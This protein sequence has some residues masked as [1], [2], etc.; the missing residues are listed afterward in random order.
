MAVGSREGVSCPASSDTRTE[1]ARDTAPL[2]KTAVGAAFGA[3]LRFTGSR[4]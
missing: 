1:G 4:E 2:G 3:E